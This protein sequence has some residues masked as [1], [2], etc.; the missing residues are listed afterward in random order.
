MRDVAAHGYKKLQFDYIWRTIKR[1]IPELE[2]NIKKLL[3]R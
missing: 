1:D 2:K 3:E